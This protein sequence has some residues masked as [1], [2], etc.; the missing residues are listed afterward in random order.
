MEMKKVLSCPLGHKCQEAV[1]GEIRQ[2]AWFVKLAGRNP[3]TGEEVDE[4]ACS[5]TWLPVLLI[6]NANTSRSTSAAVESFRNEVVKANE[7]SQLVL[8]SALTQK[9]PNK[10]IE[11]GDAGSETQ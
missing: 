7:A 11:V 8:L 6:E 1:D 5:M 4:H 2:C 10:M 9:A 3:N